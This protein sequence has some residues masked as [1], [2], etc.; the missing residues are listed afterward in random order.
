MQQHV[1]MGHGVAY[2][3]S[4]SSLWDIAMRR[5]A[6]HATLI[7]YSALCSSFILFNVSWQSTFILCCGQL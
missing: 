7:K 3:N 4:C 5:E 6:C 1:F 2:L